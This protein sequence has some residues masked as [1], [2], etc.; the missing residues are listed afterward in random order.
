MPPS[1]DARVVPSPR[2]VTAK[3]IELTVP[4]TGPV[5]VRAYGPLSRD[6]DVLVWVHGGSWARGSVEE[7]HPAYVELQRSLPVTL[8][9]ARYRSSFEA[10]HPAQLID[11]RRA[12]RAV[13]SLIGE[14]LLIAGGDS[15]GGTLVAHAAASFPSL[16]DAQVLTYP[17]MDPTCA[18]PTYDDT[19]EFPSRDWMLAAW[20]GYA[21][22]AT[23]GDLA[24]A[25]PI[26]K[27]PDARVPPTSLLVGSR[28]PVRGDVER[29]ASWL[30]TAGVAAELTISNDVCHGDF[31]R[32]GRNPVHDWIVTATRR[33]LH[34]TVRQ[35]ERQ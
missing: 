24:N 33:H 7:W 9:A 5:S 31:L 22:S 32:T 13:R 14:A 34:Q 27:P 29:Y 30:R 23:P 8:V 17:P 16:I 26:S 6:R 3:D 21:G 19:T 15:A 10:S 4:S 28:D 1:V 25:S 18:S 12:L 11:V 2:A 35:G 20:A